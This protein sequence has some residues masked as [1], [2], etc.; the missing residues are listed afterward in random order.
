[1]GFWPVIVPSMATGR[2]TPCQWMVVSSGSEFFR[3]TMSLSPTFASSS[4][5]GMVPP[6]VHALLV[7]TPVTNPCGETLASSETSST[8]G[9]ALVSVALG[10]SVS[11]KPGPLTASSDDEQLARSVSSASDERRVIWSGSW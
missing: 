10:R 1:M 6:Y 8:F 7:V 3:W 11:T 2:R 9:S 4:G 5:P